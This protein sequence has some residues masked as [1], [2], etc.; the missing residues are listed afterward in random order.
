MPLDPGA[1]A[2]LDLAKA[3]GQP[4]YETLDAKVA[5]ALYRASRA[6]LQLDPQEVG[7]VRDL[8]APGPGGPIPL[9]LYRARGVRAE[10]RLP[11]LVYYHGGGWVLGDIETHDVVCRHLVNAAGSALLSVDYRMGPEHK[12][13][14]AVDDCFA[15]LNWAV[16][17]AEA[18][19][20]D[21]SRVAVGGDSAGGNL[22]AVVSLL[23]R[24]RGGPPLALQLLI[25]PAT[26]FAG[27]YASQKTFAEG[28]LLTAANQAWFRGH[29]LRGEADAADWRASPLRAP[30]LKGVAPAWV[31]TAGYD[32]LSDE[33]EAYAKRL[34]AE[35]IPVATRRFD[36]Q[37]HG[38]ITMGKMVP[39]A[40]RALDEAGAAVKA[41]FGGR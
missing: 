16:S 35:G 32:P 5:R 38:F 4:P 21:A 26:D 29:Y 7:A 9:R 41:A 37:I 27:S 14:A 1:K 8:T 33:G 19:G 39:A 25:Y 12:F 13:P 11:L 20:I 31:L 24:D 3:A 10:T 34:A 22:S 18:L 40:G 30:S 2:V 15:V 17:E 6:V 28:Y 23:A 36:D